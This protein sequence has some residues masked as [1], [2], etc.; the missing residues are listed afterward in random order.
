MSNRHSTANAK[1]ELMIIGVRSID[2]AVESR[3]NL[4]V[5][6]PPMQSKDQRA[7][8]TKLLDRLSDKDVD[9]RDKLNNWAKNAFKSGANAFSGRDIRNLISS[10]LA[11]ARAEKVRLAHRHLELVKDAK[12]A[13]Q[14]VFTEARGR[15]KADQGS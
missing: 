7:L 4:A 13:S 15:A 14:K 1:N 5:Y 12:L 2:A 9:N 10:A 11:I 3:L 6:Y 8:C